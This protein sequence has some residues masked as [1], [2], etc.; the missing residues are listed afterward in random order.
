[1]GERF[2]DRITDFAAEFD[3]KLIFDCDV[4]SDEQIDKMF[5]DLKARG[6]TPGQISRIFDAKQGTR[7]STIDMPE[8]S[9]PRPQLPA[10][11]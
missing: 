7:L 6:V 2:K 8:L 10:G 9:I 3:S 1:M 5:A 11:A 4:S